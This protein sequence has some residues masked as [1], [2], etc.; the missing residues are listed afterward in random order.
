MFAL[1]KS[2]VPLFCLNTMKTF[3]LIVVF[4]ICANN[5]AAQTKTT[6]KKSTSKKTTTKTSTKTKTGTS[7]APAPAATTPATPPPATPAPANTPPAATPAPLTQN[8]AASGIREALSKGITK[9]V[10]VVSKTD[11]YFKNPLITIPFPSEASAV[12]NAVRKV[13]MG[14]EV[15]KVVESLNRAAENA[16]QGALPIFGDAITKLTLTDALSIVQGSNERAATDYLQ[17]TTSAQ[18]TEKFKPVI[19]QS[20]DKV[21]ATKYWETVMNAYNKIPFVKKMNPDLS[22]YVT[23]KAISGLFIMVAQEEKEIRKNPLARTTDILKK[24]FDIKF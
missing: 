23:E 6:T 11:G 4:A 2:F 15:D 9:A 3:S 17:K 22:Q 10:E 7:A 24:V 16:A 1:E 20:L 19:Q 8:D 12:E 18:L 21:D 5:I 14:N 13:G